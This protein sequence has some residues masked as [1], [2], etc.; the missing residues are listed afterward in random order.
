[1][2]V[3]CAQLY[4]AAV[5]RPISGEWHPHTP[6]QLDD[7]QLADWRAGRTAVYQPAACSRSQTST[8]AR[9]KVSNSL[10]R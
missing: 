2:R 5:I 7:E 10:K 8:N 3:D 6:E 1:M 9:P 4:P